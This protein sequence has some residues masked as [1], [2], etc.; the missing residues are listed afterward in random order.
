MKKFFS[1]SLLVGSVTLYFP[2]EQIGLW[3]LPHLPYSPDLLTTNYTWSTLTTFCRVNAPQSAG[4]RGRQIL[5]SGFLCYRNK[6]TYFSLA[7]RCC[8]EWFLFWLIK[9]CLNLVIMIENSWS[10]T[11]IRF[12]PTSH[13]QWILVLR[14]VLTS[15]TGFLVFLLFCV[16]V[17]EFCSKWF[18]LVFPLIYQLLWEHTSNLAD[19]VWLEQNLA[20][21]SPPRAPLSASAVAATSAGTM[22]SC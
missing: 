12:A 20:D 22:N 5:K 10:K 13:L 14:S 9:M 4:G 1:N 8:L 6:Q 7:K 15:E 17:T 16:P 2:V 3:S 11:T 18:S 19:V 21:F